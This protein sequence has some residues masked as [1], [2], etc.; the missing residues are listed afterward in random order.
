MIRKLHPEDR[1]QIL[2]IV[3]SIDIFDAEEKDVALELVDEAIAKPQQ[4][5]YNIFVYEEENKVLGYHCTGQRALTDGVFDMYWI[6]VDPN[7]QNKGIGK[8][9]LE[10][11]EN[12]AKERNGRLIL[13][14]T[15]SRGVYTPTRSF[16]LKNHYSILAEIKDF[17][18]KNDNLVIFG[19][20]IKI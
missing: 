5:Y 2:R 10:H 18:S 6:V 17:Y 3:S 1:E 4:E 16:Y 20:Y 11:V 14:E 12:F 13:A 15:S 19:K 7:V 9:L 8:K